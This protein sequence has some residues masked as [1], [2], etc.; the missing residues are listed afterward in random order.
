MNRKRVT[1]ISLSLGGLSSDDRQ[2][3]PDA[4]LLRQGLNRASNVAADATFSASDAQF[5]GL[6]LRS[7]LRHDRFGLL[8]EKLTYLSDNATLG[9]SAFPTEVYQHIKHRAADA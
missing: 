7:S 1:A 5:F 3:V 8:V 4:I 6:H 9:P 2:L